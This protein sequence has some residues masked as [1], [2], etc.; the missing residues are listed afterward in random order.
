MG[1]ASME[2]HHANGDLVA[3]LSGTDEAGQQRGSG[4]PSGGL[5]KTP[6]GQGGGTHAVIGFLPSTQVETRFEAFGFELE[7][8]LRVLSR[9]FEIAARETNSLDEP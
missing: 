5:Q 2:T 4:S 3:R 7:F 1:F 9:S 8:G 6:P